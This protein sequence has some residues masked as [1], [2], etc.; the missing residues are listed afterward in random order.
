MQHTT[1]NYLLIPH[2]QVFL[3]KG[4]QQQLFEN[5]DRFHLMSKHQFGSENIFLTQKP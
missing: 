3:K 2:R 1:D 5:L 4:F